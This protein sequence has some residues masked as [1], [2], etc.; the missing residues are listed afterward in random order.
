M[1]LLRTYFLIF[2]ALICSSAHAATTA[3]TALTPAQIAEVTAFMMQQPNPNVNTNGIGIYV[4]D[5]MNSMDALGPYK[6]FKSA[7]LKTFLIGKT[8]TVTTS[9]KLKIQ[10]D[11]LIGDVTLLD[12]LL[13]PGGALSTAMESDNTDTLNWIK[14]I[15]STTIYTTSVCTGAWILGSAGLLEGKKATTNWYNAKQMLTKYGAIYQNKRWVQDGKYWTSAGVSAGIDMALAIVLKLYGPEYTQAVM[16]D[17]EYDPKPPIS[18]GS[19]AK[20]KA[21]PRQHMQW[22]YDYYLLPFV[23]KTLTPAGTVDAKGC[24]SPQQWDD[25]MKMCMQFCLIKKGNLMF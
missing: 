11:K 13:V 8:S 22:M 23:N 10:T 18:G 2:F 19:P 7:G 15:D 6:V 9:D 25:G 20:T 5:G 4:Y 14:Q 21:K 16:L 12:I 17:L 1:K 3:T 24:V